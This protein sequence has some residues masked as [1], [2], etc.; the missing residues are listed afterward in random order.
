[1]ARVTKRDMVSALIKLSKAPSLREE[2][3]ELLSLYMKR[4][5]LITYGLLGAGQDYSYVKRYTMFKYL[6]AISSLFYSSL[7]LRWFLSVPMTLS[8]AF[9]F[10][11]TF[12][13][14][15]EI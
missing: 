6:N 9:P 15:K 14:G 11:C 5:A 13:E 7:M 12:G 2:A 10:L 1:M 4:S 8:L 3:W